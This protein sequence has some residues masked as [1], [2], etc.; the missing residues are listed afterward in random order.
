M[1]S[2]YPLVL[3]AER[4]DHCVQVV[5]SALGMDEATLTCDSRIMKT[6]NK[7]CSQE[8]QEEG[9]NPVKSAAEKRH[10]LKKRFR[11]Q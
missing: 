2:F 4:V 1:G 6:N 10:R 3:A 11:R 7:Q 9:K 8:Q 5:V